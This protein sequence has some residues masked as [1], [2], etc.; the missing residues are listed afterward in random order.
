MS[1]N[2]FVDWKRHPVTQQVFSQLQG[3]ITQL[4]EELVEQTVEGNQLRMVEKASAIKAYRDLL[5]IEF[6]EP[7]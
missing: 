1:K 6:E 4:S 7:Q 3:M 5:N 2:D